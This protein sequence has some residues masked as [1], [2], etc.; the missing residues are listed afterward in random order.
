M[1]KYLQDLLDGLSKN[2]T[3]IDLI[4]FALCILI[5]LLGSII[6]MFMYL[7]LYDRKNSA[8]G[9]YKSFLLIGPSV[10]GMFL[11]IQ[12]SLPLSL[13]LLGA[14][15]FIRFRTPIKDPE[16]VAY[17]LLL[18]ASSIACATYNFALGAIILAIVFVAQL[19]NKK[20]RTNK[21][22]NERVGHILISTHSETINEKAITEAINEKLKD[23]SLKNI[24]KNG[25]SVNFH[26][27][28]LNKKP[29]SYDE[30]LAKLNKISKISSL[31]IILD[32]GNV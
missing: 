17:I 26:Y 3:N 25:E 24:S 31:N 15:S 16:E 29:V 18:I 11:A 13:G 7:Y 6:V 4:G 1:N 9:V 10:T 27:T 19:F 20:L 8:S 23:T 22:F 14:L 2:N 21:F 30:L 28:F 5:S 32:E 12:F